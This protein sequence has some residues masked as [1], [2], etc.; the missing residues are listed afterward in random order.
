M[1]KHY[2]LQLLEKAIN[3]AL[4]LDEHMHDKLLALHPKT[5]QVII[6]PLRVSFYIQFFNGQ[7]RLLTKSDTPADT[8]IQSS[9]IGLIR[10]SLLPASKTRSLFNDRI[11]MTGDITL[12]QQVKQLFDEIDIDWEGHLARF[13]GDVAAYQISTLVRKGLDFGHHFNQSM[14]F[15]LNEYVHE[16]LRFFPTK[17]ELNDFF[18]DV[19]ELSLATERAEA[20]IKQ[21]MS[22]YEI[23]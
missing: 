22:H 1:L 14:H 23:D 4:S 12:G 9:P 13:T 10:L 18:N 11:Q 21:L 20:H 6:M 16:E 2:S 7:M 15:S 19:D 8:I 3:S 5:L 17:A